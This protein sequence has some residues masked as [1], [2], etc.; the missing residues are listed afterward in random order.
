MS[1]LKPALRSVAKFLSQERRPKIELTFSIS[2]RSGYRWQTF[3]QF[4]SRAVRRV[5]AFHFRACPC[6]E[7]EQ[8]MRKPCCGLERWSD[9]QP[10]SPDKADFGLTRGGVTKVRQRQVK[11]Q[12]EQTTHHVIAPRSASRL[13]LRSLILSQALS[14]DGV[15]SDKEV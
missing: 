11:R 3:R 13:P 1:R 14:I 7:R 8:V 5:R 4:V 6:N 9:S 2:V 10:H 12:L 15:M